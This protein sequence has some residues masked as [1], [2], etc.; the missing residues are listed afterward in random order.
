L[1]FQQHS[2]NPADIYGVIETAGLSTLFYYGPKL[3]V[4]SP[5]VRS[6]RSLGFII[7]QK[8]WAEIWYAMGAIPKTIQHLLV[9]ATIPLAYPRTESAE[10]LVRAASSFALSMHSLVDFSERLVKKNS[11]RDLKWTEKFSRSAFYRGLVNIFEEPE[12]MDDIKDHW[13]DP[14]HIKERDMFLLGLQQF[15]KERSCRV[16][17]LSGDVHVAAVGFFKTNNRV[18]GSEYLFPEEDYRLMYQIVSSAIG[19]RPPPSR[20]VNHINNSAKEVIVND[21]TLENMLKLFRTDLN[22]NVSKNQVLM[23]ARNWCSI[24][25]EKNTLY[26]DIRVECDKRSPYGHTKSYVVKVPHLQVK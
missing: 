8:S 21:Y 11:N 18:F 10:S 26:F 16:T 12:L 6:Q 9:N 4:L 23:R 14:I 20:M 1:L 24:T 25:E 5:D 19:N 22:G 17:F 7:P 13:I 15:A 2:A 3:A